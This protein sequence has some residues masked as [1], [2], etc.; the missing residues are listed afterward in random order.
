[1]F[2]TLAKQMNMGKKSLLVVIDTTL[3]I[4]EDGHGCFYLLATQISFCYEMPVLLLLPYLKISLFVVRS[5]FLIAT[6]RQ[7]LQPRK[8]NALD[9]GSQGHR[10]PYSKG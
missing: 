1:L 9:K 3:I 8:T 2:S 7:L 10:P 5:E 4:S 6:P